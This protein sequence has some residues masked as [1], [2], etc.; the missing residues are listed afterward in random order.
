MISRI[1]AALVTVVSV[2]LAA[3]LTGAFAQ[4]QAETPTDEDVADAMD[5]AVNNSIMIL[6][7][8]I[9][10]LFVGELRLPVLGK[11]ED[12]ADSLSAVFLLEEADEWSDAVLRDAAQGWYLSPYNGKGELGDW[13]FMGQHSL[14]K[15]RSFFFVCM[16]VGNNPE[17]YGELATEYEMDAAKQEHCGYEYRQAAESWAQVLEPYELDEDSQPVGQI[18]VQYDDPGEHGAVAE[19]LQA[20]RFLEEAAEMINENYVIPRDL[21]FRATQ[22]GQSNAYYIPGEAEVRFCYEYTKH[23][24]GLYLESFA[25]LQDDEEADADAAETDEADAQ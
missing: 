19:A 22:C 11:N 24:A 2:A 3:P 15:Q 16:M 14:D 25:N 6:Y 23:L 4:D 9:G 12:A 17:Y 5:F 7:H 18:T 1:A 13:A 8:E 10:H 21:T 20:D